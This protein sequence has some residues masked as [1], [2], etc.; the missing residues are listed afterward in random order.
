MVDSLN[1][2]DKIDLAGLRNRRRIGFKCNKIFME[3]IES[4]VVEQRNYPLSFIFKC[5]NRIAFFCECT[6]L[7]LNNIGKDCIFYLVI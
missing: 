6:A 5:V 2:H 7:T 1:M 4:V 3:T